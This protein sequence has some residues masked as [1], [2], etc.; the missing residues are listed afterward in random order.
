[1]HREVE[2]GDDRTEAMEHGGDGLS[3]HGIE[4]RLRPI[5]VIELER[6]PGRHQEQE[7][8][9]DQSMK[10]A[11]QR[12]ETRVLLG[13]FT[14]QDPLLA[15]LP[16]IARV[17]GHR[18][19][20]PEQRV[21][22][23]EAHGPDEERRHEPEGIVEL[24]V[25]LLVLVIGVDDVHRKV[26]VGVRVTFPARL[27]AALAADPGFGAVGRCDVVMTVTVVASRHVGSAQCDRLAVEGVAVAVKLLLVTLAAHAIG[28][29]SEFGGG[30]QRDHVRRVT[31][32]ADRGLDIVGRE[33]LAVDA[34]FE[35]LLHQDMALATGIGDLFSADPGIR[36]RV[37]EDVVAAMAVVAARSHGEPVD[38]QRLAVNGV[39]EVVDRRLVMD[40][41]GL[42]NDFVLM[43]LG[44][45]LVEVELVGPRLP[46]GGGKDVVTAVAIRAGG[47]VL[48]ALRVPLSVNAPVV[49]RDHLVVTTGAGTVEQERLA[50]VVGRVLEVLRSLVAI[51]AR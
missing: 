31:R 38:Q 29:Q 13:V 20:E 36:I 14:S 50:L 43:T 42:E 11:I 34:R 30:W 27:D 9:D 10:E 37:G 45:G 39:E 1:M 28:V 21:Q 5:G 49:L 25:R 48:V 19:V 3:P 24:R 33:R 23:E 47:R 2:D 12:R 32:G 51:R 15:P 35:G 26:G 6:H 17:E 16:R 18:P 46:V 40:G 7:A 4:Q 22:G 8:A 41:T 44:A